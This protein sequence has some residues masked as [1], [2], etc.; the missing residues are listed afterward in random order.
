MS[1]RTVFSYFFRVVFRLCLACLCRGMSNEARTMGCANA[2]GNGVDVL[3]FRI[4]KH[5]SV[6]AQ[7]GFED[8]RDNRMRTGH[9]KIEPVDILLSAR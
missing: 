6:P 9:P 1:V 7:N 5:S 3:L 4:G 2:L 8:T